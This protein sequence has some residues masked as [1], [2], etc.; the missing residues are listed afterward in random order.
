MRDARGDILK[1]GGPHGSGNVETFDSLLTR[2]T[3]RATPFVV[4]MNII[5]YGYRDD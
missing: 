3:S 4:S 2:T 1:N 5:Y